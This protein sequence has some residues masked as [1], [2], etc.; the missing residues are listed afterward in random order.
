MIKATKGMVTINGDVV[1]LIA[2]VT[3]VMAAAV[4]SL[5][6]D[7]YKESA[8]IADMKGI[9]QS[10][11]EHY[12]DPEVGYKAALPYIDSLFESEPKEPETS[13]PKEPETDDSELDWLIDKM[14]DVLERRAK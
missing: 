7:G 13:E 10:A 9:A 8:A 4:Q 11:I 3:T 5:V 1:E 12:D 14:L 2:D 6:N